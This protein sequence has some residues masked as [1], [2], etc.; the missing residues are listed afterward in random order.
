MEGTAPSPDLPAE[1]LHLAGKVL[2]GQPD[3]YAGDAPA[4]D[5]IPVKFVQSKVALGIKHKFLHFVCRGLCIGNQAG[6]QA[7]SD[8]RRDLLS[9]RRFD[10]AEGRVLPLSTRPS[11]VCQN[12][13]SCLYADAVPADRRSG[14]YQMQGFF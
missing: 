3:M 13:S 9:S 14:T 2:T 7:G 5:G 6:R 4:Y 8:T 12:D 11:A 10:K 1:K